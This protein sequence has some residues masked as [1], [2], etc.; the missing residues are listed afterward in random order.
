MYEPKFTSL[1]VPCLRKKTVK[2]GKNDNQE[3]KCYFCKMK[4]EITHHCPDCQ[5]TNIKKNGKKASRKQNYFCK[6]CG[7]QF[8]GDHALL[9]KG[10]HSF[11]IHRIL[12]MPVRGVGIRDVAE[13]EGI[14]IKK[15]LSVLVS[16][17]HTL[18]PRQ[19]HYDS[20]EFDEFWTYVRKKEN[21]IWLIYAYHCATG[22]IVAHV[23]GKRNLK[24][25]KK[26][27]NK[28]SSLGISFD[29]VYTDNRESFNAAFSSDNHVI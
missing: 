17:N 3:I 10:C 23:W 14:S 9:Y 18:K 2:V 13:I 28:L 7:R 11:L 6:K 29:T 25:A 27:R 24:T 19:I 26:L 4:I 22:E 15:A 8:T 20:L 1:I 21:R 16:S 5:G 12:M